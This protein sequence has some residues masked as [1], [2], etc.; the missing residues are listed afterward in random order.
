VD[1]AIST[2]S[3]SLDTPA[4]LERA[5][6]LGL[7]A[8]QVNLQPGEFRYG[9][10]RTIDLG[11]YERLAEALAARGLRAV[12]V[13]H[14]P[15]SGAQAFSGEVRGEL[16]KAAARVL[17]LLHAPV[18]VVHPADLFTSHEALERYF[19]GGPEVAPPVVAGFDEC[20]ARLAD[21]RAALALENV[22]YWRG[23]PLTNRPEHLARVLADLAIYAVLDVRRALPARA[24]PEIAANALSRWVEA[25]GARTLLLHLH[26][27]D[28]RAGREHAGGEHAGGEHAPPLAA[29]WAALAPLLRRTRARAAVL[30]VDA[31]H[32]E[33]QIAR[34]REYI[35]SLLGGED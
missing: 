21:Q 8:V 34:S 22:S 29:D 35:T 12:A 13:H 23:A 33:E 16:L 6:A 27:R 3:L 5:A 15:L 24:A 30:E 19:A 32:G 7:R 1:I 28:A 20:W 26:D 11:F 18:L 10:T 2:G 25:I 4:A 14:V 31:R 17:A 9:F